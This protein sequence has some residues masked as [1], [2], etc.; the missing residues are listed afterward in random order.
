MNLLIIFVVLFGHWLS[1]F[2]LQK[3]KQKPS[4]DKSLKTKVKKTLKNLVPHTIHYS[5]ILTGLIFILDLFNV[6]GAQ[7]WW[8]TPLLFIIIFITHYI[9]DFIITMVNSEYLKKNKRHEYFV[10]IGL[11]QLIHYMTLFITIH[12]LYF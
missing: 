8:N 2:V 12:Y 3:N 11:D 4:K 1:D 9:T 10:M 5:L 6:F 7:S